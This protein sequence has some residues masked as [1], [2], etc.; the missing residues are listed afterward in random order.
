MPNSPRSL[1]AS[2]SSSRAEGQRTVRGCVR[3]SLT[4]DT[5]ASRPH[6]WRH[7]ACLTPS[8]SRSPDSKNTPQ[9]GVL[10]PALTFL[11]VAIVRKIFFV[12]RLL[13]PSRGGNYT[14]RMPQKGHRAKRFQ[15][16]LSKRRY[17]PRN[18]VVTTIPNRI[19]QRSSVKTALQVTRLRRSAMPQALAIFRLIT[20]G[21]GLSDSL[22]PLLNRTTDSSQTSSAFPCFKRPF[23][24]LGG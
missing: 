24:L 8:A 10:E 15:Y 18:A 21:R 14:T 5:A 11:D 6:R 7:S 16:C 20:S 2:R 3:R 1:A 4:A 23:S 17:D 19:V 12:D 13:D 9:E 22:G